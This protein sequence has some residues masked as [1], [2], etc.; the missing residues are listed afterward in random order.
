MSLPDLPEQEQAELLDELQ[1]M[2][3]PKV[4]VTCPGCKGLRFVGVPFKLEVWQIHIQPPDGEPCETCKGEG[5]IE[6]YTVTTYEHAMR[7]AEALAGVAKTQS[8]RAAAFD[9]RISRLQAEKTAAVKP[10]QRRAESLQYLLV[11]FHR[12][13]LAADKRQKTVTL[14][15]GVELVSRKA[16]DGMDY[17]DEKAL[18]THLLAT[19]PQFVRPTVAKD[20]L[21][22]AIAYND[23][24]AAY[25]KETGEALPGV[26]F[27]LGETLH[28]VRF[29]GSDEE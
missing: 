8:E 18:A 22:K 20:S 5:I 27:Q 29:G 9:S 26:K 3:L 11:E 25:I 6:R 13:V 4:R 7:L 28:K 16:P 23:D 15:D 1:A 10:L 2:E 21:K 14:C 24:G 12:S 17:G 19:Y